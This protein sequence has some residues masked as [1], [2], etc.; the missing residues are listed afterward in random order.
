MLASKATIV[1]W[2]SICTL[3]INELNSDT[4]QRKIEIF[5][6]IIK[7]KLG[8]AMTSPNKSLTSAFIPYSDG[9]LYPHAL[10]EVDEYPVQTNGTAVF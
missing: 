3:E 8:I 1:P 5:D 4:E 7:D 2:Q 9:D 6:N 10:H